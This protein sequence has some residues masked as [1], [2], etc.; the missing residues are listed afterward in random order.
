MIDVKYIKN[1]LITPDRANLNMKPIS[2]DD[3]FLLFILFLYCTHKDNKP[4]L[5]HEINIRTLKLRVHTFL[6]F[7]SLSFTTLF[8]SHSYPH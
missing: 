3:A 8:H 1:S 7:A 6:F 4:W 2:K 5:F